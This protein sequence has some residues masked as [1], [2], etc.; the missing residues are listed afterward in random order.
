[1]ELTVSLIEMF[2]TLIV[3]VLTFLFSNSPIFRGYRC[4]TM[5]K[6]EEE[7]N[8]RHAVKEHHAVDQFQNNLGQGSLTSNQIIDSAST[9]IALD[10]IEGALTGGIAGSTAGIATSPINGGR[11]FQA[12]TIVTCAAGGGTYTAIGSMKE[13]SGMRDEDQFSKKDNEN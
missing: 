11:I 5:Q 12:E 6:D 4:E 9:K 7:E 1:V 3:K 8:D 13:L 2:I 10:T